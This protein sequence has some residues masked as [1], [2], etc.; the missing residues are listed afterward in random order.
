MALDT[1]DMTQ[2][3]MAL[4]FNANHELLRLTGQVYN[5]VTRKPGSHGYTVPNTIKLFPVLKDL[6][7]SSAEWVDWR[8]NWSYSQTG[9]FTQWC[10]SFTWSRRTR[11]LMANISQLHRLFLYEA[12]RSTR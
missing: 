10:L 6:S 11:T 8:M 5:R 4:T 2:T 12:K 3:R 7:Q 1:I 9:T